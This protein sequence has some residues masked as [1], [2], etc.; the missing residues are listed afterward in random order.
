MLGD[1]SMQEWLEQ[2]AESHQR[3]RKPPEFFRG[4]RRLFVGLR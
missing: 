2:H 3:A 1:R 4:W